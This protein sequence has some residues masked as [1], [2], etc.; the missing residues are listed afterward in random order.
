MTV[1][2]YRFDDAEAPIL[3][4]EAG[5]IVALLDACLVNGY[6]AKPG[7]GWSKPFAD[8]NKGVYQQGAGSN[9]F[10]LQVDGTVLNYPIFRGFTAMSDLVTGTGQF[11]TTLQMA[12]GLRA[13]NSA[14]NDATPRPWLI[15][16]D[17]K[18]F[19]LYIGYQDTIAVGLATTVPGQIVFFGDI[20]SYLA[21]DAY[22]T[23]L[24]AST[25]MSTSTSS[26]GAGHVYYSGLAGHYIARNIAQA[27]ESVNYTKMCDS[28]GIYPS[29]S[30]QSMGLSGTPYP[31]GITGGMLLSPVWVI[32]PANILTRGYM[33]G[34]W[35]PMHPLPAIAGSTFEGTLNGGVSGKTFIN[36]NCSR[37]GNMAKVVLELSDTWE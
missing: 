19:Y 24:I 15:A 31:D 25:G 26:F 36:L 4:A 5:S 17:S 23:M 35:A 7:A 30:A 11:P 6:G 13:V 27:T 2:V 37:T 1:T 34:L 10:F 29:T 12:N 9:G 8:V 28:R 18:R 14:S 16:A 22:H 20:I 33:P 3:T 21:N 32:E